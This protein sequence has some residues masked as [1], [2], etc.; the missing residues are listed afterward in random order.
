VIFS[1]GA[2]ITVV[3]VSRP[4]A[5]VARGTVLKYRKE[6]GTMKNAF[7][8]LVVLLAAATVMTA[9]GAGGSASGQGGSG[10]TTAAV[11]T[12]SAGATASGGGSAAAGDPK[13]GEAL[14]NSATIGSNPGCKT[15]HTVDGSKLVGPS[16]QGVASRAG[17]RVPGQSAEEYMRTSI[18]DPNAYVVP[19]FPSG[20]MP[21]FKTVLSDTQ[22][23][24]IVAYLMTLK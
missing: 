16:L 11:P 12:S 6:G 7:F 15:C 22:L 18:T 8:V 24:D 21:S 5:A 23:N 19:G 10:S 9:C 13:A 20:V 4:I 3:L 1:L 14:F 2:M 17:S